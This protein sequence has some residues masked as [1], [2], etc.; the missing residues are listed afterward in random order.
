M[1]GGEYYPHHLHLQAQRPAKLSTQNWYCLG[2]LLARRITI[3]FIR[4]TEE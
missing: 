4:A 2:V 3:S 1:N